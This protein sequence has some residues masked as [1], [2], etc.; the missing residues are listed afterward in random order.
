[1]WLFGAFRS[2]ASAL[3][4]QLLSLTNHGARITLFYMKFTDAITRM[5]RA[6]DPDRGAER[7]V[8]FDGQLADVVAGAAGCSPYL[9]GLIGKH[10]EWLQGAFADP[11]AALRG[12]LTAVAGYASN[13]PLSELSPSLRRSKGRI[14]L[15]TALADLAGVWPLESVTTAL[16]YLADAALQTA[17]DA[18]FAAR[19][20]RGHLPWL[21]EDDLATNGG[22]VVLAMGKMGAFELNYSSDIDLICLFDDSRYARDDVADVR[23]AFVQIIRAVTKTISAQTRDGYVFRTDLRLRPDA[24]VTPVCMSMSAAELYYEA[25]GRTWER[26]AHIKRGCARAITKPERL[27]LSGF[28]LSFGASIWTL[29][30]FKT[31]MT[32]AS[33]FGHTRGWQ[34]LFHCPSIT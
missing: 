22:L 28:D 1:M 34:G 24:A 11:E 33:K 31:P 14:A 6:F 2:R 13:V 12:E 21:T 19:F 10:H 23:H 20:K 30:Q 15:L 26:A 5:P 16:T 17:L 9:R 29:Q 32:C 7:A 3:F 18:E 4:D 8:L 27:I 25:E